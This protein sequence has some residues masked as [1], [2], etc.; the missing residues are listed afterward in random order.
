MNK[1]ELTEI[2]IAVIKKQLNEEYSPF[3]SEE[4]EQL[5]YNSMI[6]KAEALL[7]ELDA[8]ES[9]GDDLVAWFWNKYQE[10]EACE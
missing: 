10:Q 3:F 7:D 5:A 6:D 1:I 4:E 2:E 9:M 8:Y